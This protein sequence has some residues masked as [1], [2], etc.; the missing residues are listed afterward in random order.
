MPRSKRTEVASAAHLPRPAPPDVL[1]DGSNRFRYLA[2]ADGVNDWVHH[3]FLRDGAPLHN[4]DHAHLIDADVAYLWAAVENLRRMRRVVG[5]C[6]EV[7]IRAGGWQRARQ[8]QQ[9]C[10]WFGRVPAFL[11]TLDA[12]YAREC[13]DLEWC[14]LVEHELYHIGQRTDEF[15][16]PAFS[17]DGMPKLGIRGHDVE[18]FVGIVRRY[19][20]GGGAGDTAKLVDA[21]RRAPEVAHVDIARACGTC[22]LRA[23]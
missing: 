22:I 21:A 20:I 1:F 2:P 11:I 9:L 14:A 15:G 8:E 18:E 13:S 12:H 6:E 16:A 23:A 5:Q 4:E 17:K 7:M 3:T 10:E 19:G